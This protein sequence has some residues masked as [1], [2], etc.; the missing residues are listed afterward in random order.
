MIKRLK[1]KFFL[2][3]T[4]K[5][6][7]NL[8]GKFLVRKINNH[9]LAGKI[10]EVEAYHGF[11][12]CA[13]HAFRGKTSR[14]EVMFG[15]AGFSYIYLVYGINHCLNFVT[16][17]KDFPAA[18]LIRAVEPTEGIELM[19]K[20]RKNKHFD[21]LTSGPGKLC[22]AFGINRQLN[23]CDIIKSKNLWIEDRGE[24]INPQDIHAAERIGVDYAGER[25]SK[26]KWRFFVK[27]NKFVS[28]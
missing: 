28:R 3:P 1:R 25:W 2:Q 9:K 17:K 14:N 10:V 18:V 6:A 7:K 8:L 21:N 24:K 16:G 4:L 13:S 11:D 12:D 20:F 15:Q 22:Q 23:I 19:K 27:N 26:I 5:V